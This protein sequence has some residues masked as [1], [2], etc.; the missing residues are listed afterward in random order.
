[1]L[2]WWDITL[3]ILTSLYT[4]SHVLM[5]AFGGGDAITAPGPAA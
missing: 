4:V 2:N 1:M 5:K 3:I